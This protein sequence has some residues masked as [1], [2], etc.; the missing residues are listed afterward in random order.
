MLAKVNSS[1]VIGIDAHAVEV[2]VDISNGLPGFNIVGLPDTACR[3]SADR[4]HHDWDFDL[5]PGDLREEP[6]TQLPREV[7]VLLGVG[8]QLRGL[9]SIRMPDATHGV[10]ITLRAQ[11]VPLG[12]IAKRNRL[13]TDRAGAVDVICQE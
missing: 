13:P 5:W 2:E 3:E 1:S 7:D 4:V 9:A 10:E 12:K 11:T 6:A 8:R